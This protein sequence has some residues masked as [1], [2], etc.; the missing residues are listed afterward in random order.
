MHGKKRP[1]HKTCKNKTSCEKDTSKA[2]FCLADT[3]ASQHH[4]V[5]S[6]SKTNRFMCRIEGC[7]EWFSRSTN[8]ARHEATHTAQDPKFQCPECP[9]VF[10]SI[11]N[12]DR[13]VR[14]VHPKTTGSHR[15]DDCGKIFSNKRSWQRHAHEVHPKTTASHRCDFCGKTFRLKRLVL[16][17]MENMHGQ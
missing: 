17:H 13:H 11:Y 15:C 4:V 9:C 12:R 8:R 5:A 10:K 3:A 14:E 16:K 2:N 6:H 1:Y 7:G